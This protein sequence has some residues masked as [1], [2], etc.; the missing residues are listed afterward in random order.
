MVSLQTS[1]I[2]LTDASL[3]QASSRLYTTTVPSVS[4]LR[5]GFDFYAYGGTGADGIS[6]FLVDGK[7]LMPLAGGS[8]GS[9]G[10]GGTPD[11]YLGIGFDAFGKFAGTTGGYSGGR[12]FTPD[13]ITVRGS[14]AT[15]YEYLT[16]TDTLPVSLDNPGAGAT[17]ND[18]RRRAEVILSPE[19]SLTVQ[20]DL[21][22][23]GTFTD[24]GELAINPF[25]VIQKNG[26]LPASFR[27][28]FAAATGALTNIHEVGNF[29][30]TTFD[31]TP[32]PGIFEGDFI[33][34]GGSDNATPA[35]GRDENQVT[36]SKS[37]DTF[38]FS[39]ATKRSALRTST[40]RSLDRITDFNFNEGDRF[41]L[42]YD[43][44][45]NTIERP[46]RVYNAGRV[47]GK[48]LQDA[49][50]T[51][52]ADKLTRKKG[53]QSLKA[54]ESIF[55]RLGSRTFFAVNDDKA[56][57]SSRNDLVAEVTGI[58]FKPGDAKPG[59][60]AIRNYFI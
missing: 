32:I 54:D 48:N 24:P 2:R 59:A 25:N 57:F 53:S 34:T 33:T 42:D 3:N 58:Q 55:F 6:F 17:R 13:A 18:S 60:L 4:G 11:G 47:K 7:Q 56:T 19:G 36:G 21:N 35:V 28:G 30:V 40:I 29:S 39:G 52:Y 41:K 16:G 37:A 49:L 22:D 45:L 46:K 27:F 9:L 10:Y 8:G 38:I 12:G 5:I 23:N 43:N 50:K 44:N 1:V 31:G 51:A 26:S 20:V 15:N 14:A